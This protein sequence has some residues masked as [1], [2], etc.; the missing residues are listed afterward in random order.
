MSAAEPVSCIYRGRVMHHRLGPTPHRF[1]YRVFSLFL[2][3]DRID[4]LQQRLWPFTLARARWF[5]VRAADHATGDFGALLLWAREGFAA[6]GI[7][8][9][10]ARIFLSCFPRVLGYAFKPLSLFYC[11]EEGRVR[12]VLAEVRNTFGGRHVYAAHAASRGHQGLSARVPKAFFVSPFMRSDVDYRFR[13]PCPGPA[14]SV[15][16]SAERDGRTLLTAVHRARRLE[17]SAANLARCLALDGAM[18]FK[19]TAAIHLEALRLAAK[20]YPF[21]TPAREPAAAQPRTAGEPS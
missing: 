19:I 2:E 6:H 15:G 7:A 20:G 16:I 13:L 5:G 18:T 8:T 12:A 3:L 1:G 10:R 17:L 4:E 21:R 14:L 11:I 9:A